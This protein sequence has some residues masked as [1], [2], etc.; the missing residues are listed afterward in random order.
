MGGGGECE[1]GPRQWSGEQ[2][3]RRSQIVGGVGGRQRG[4][5]N[6]NKFYNLF[7]FSTDQCSI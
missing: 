4:F 6:R 5:M 7:K 2:A 1:A 3:R